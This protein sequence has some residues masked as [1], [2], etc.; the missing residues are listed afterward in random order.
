M[1]NKIG[2]LYAK[3]AT[4][5]TLPLRTRRS[6]SLP[7]LVMIAVGAV[8]PAVGALDTTAATTL[9]LNYNNNGGYVSS[10]TNASHWTANAG[11]TAT[12]PQLMDADV[13]PNPDA[14]GYD[15]Y[16]GNNYSL[17]TFKI[18]AATS[19]YA[20]KLITF[21]GRSL[22][23]GPGAFWPACAYE[24]LPLRIADLHFREESRV[25]LSTSCG[26]TN[27]TI[28]VESSASKPL[29]IANGG[30][31]GVEFKFSLYASTLVGNASANIL[32]GGAGYGPSAFFF[33]GNSSG[34]LGTIRCETGGKTSTLELDKGTDL[35]HATITLKATSGSAAA[36]LSMNQGTT[37]SVGTLNLYNYGQTSNDKSTSTFGTVNVYGGGTLMNKTAGGTMTIGTL[38]QSGGQTTF[39]ANTCIQPQAFHITGGKLVIGQKATVGITTVNGASGNVTFGFNYNTDEHRYGCANVT[40][41]FAGPVTL[42]LDATGLTEFYKGLSSAHT[43]VKI[44]KT[45]VAAPP[46]AA[47]F[48]VSVPDSYG[49]MLANDLVRIDED[50][51]T[52]NVVLVPPQY[53]YLTQTLKQGVPWTSSSTNVWSDGQTPHDDAD[54][55][56]R[57]QFYS[58]GNVSSTEC[59]FNMKSLTISATELWLANRDARFPKLTLEAASLE[60]NNGSLTSSSPLNNIYASEIHIRAG[61]LGN[62]R[63]YG[64]AIFNVYAPLTGGGIFQTLNRGTAKPF[65]VNTNYGNSTL[66][67]MQASPD[68]TGKIRTWKYAG[69]TYPYSLEDSTKLG[70]AVPL[71]LGG[72]L[73]TFMFD[74]LE[75]NLFGCLKP[76]AS[77]TLDTANRGIFVNWFGRM[78]VESNLVF[79]VNSRLTMGGTL[80]KMGAGTLWL[81]ASTAPK[82]TGAQLADPPSAA[83]AD[84]TNLVRVLEGAF[85]ATTT[86]AVDGLALSFAEGGKLAVDVAATGDVAA[87]GLCNKKGTV[88]FDG[89]NLTVAISPPEEL[90][91]ATV[92]VLT[93]PTAQAAAFLDNGTPRFVADASKNY[94]TRFS[95]EE[96][97]TAGLTTFKVTV[98]RAG[99]TVIFR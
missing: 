91:Y 66:N 68:F 21:G 64:G 83:G 78:L 30:N 3:V 99:M 33:S 59:R 15:Y 76:L 65:N 8:L 9:T 49:F 34:Y 29:L 94:R 26:L 98:A 95:Y 55:L 57:Y 2:F 58:Y 37:I 75:L 22:H 97:V 86:N 92:G 20:D 61:T 45:A 62:M 73:D 90:S 54:Y 42:L 36:T 84:G 43:V 88:S 11:G 50:T 77:M 35:S 80:E 27:S 60:S 56:S 72:P 38:N 23:V 67:L 96:D 74:A 47:D 31:S 85:G 12:A 1:G 52:W 44:A 87:Y 6:A 93:V 51:D 48:P 89:A 40:N 7:V 14:A 4:S 71:A 32:V 13:S 46:S 5:A 25:S 70:I 18:D 28:T 82:F 79:H 53:I 63:P 17:R 10:L 81:G 16:V 41:S 19:P 69:G 39:G 24:K